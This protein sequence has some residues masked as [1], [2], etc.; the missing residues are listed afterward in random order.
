MVLGLTGGIASGKST[1]SGFFAAEGAHILDADRVARAVV[2]P[3]NPAWREI[4]HRFGNE[5]FHADGTLDRKK[6]ADRVFHDEEARGILNR[7]VH[8]HV[9]AEEGRLIEEW[10]EKDPAGIVV[11]DAALLI[12]AGSHRR[13][14]RVLVAY[15]EEEIQ[16]RRLMERDSLSRQEAL[17]RLAAQMP[18]K[19][20]LA[21]ADHIVDTGGT[22]ESIR[23]QVREIVEGLRRQGAAAAGKIIDSFCAL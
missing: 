17:A 5:Y 14:D 22:R 18:L 13:V 10:R 9:M 4:Q 12:E 23:R 1:V 7:I 2:E 21:Y 6:M 11:L 16:I 15:V 20:K 3:G 19:E 8:P